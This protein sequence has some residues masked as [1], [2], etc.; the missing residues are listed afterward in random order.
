MFKQILSQLKN[1]PGLDI[2][3]NE[4]MSRH[5]TFKIGGPAR[6]FL[7]AHTTD[8][9]ASAYNILQK[10][11]ITPLILGNGSNLLVSDSG[12]DGI[13]LKL[14]CNKITVSGNMIF[15]E[16][17]ALLSSIASVAQKEALTGLEFAHG[18]PG[19]V[20]GAVVMNAGAYGGEI[21]D[22]L[23][24][25]VCLSPVGISEIPN[26]D[27]NFGYRDSIYKRNPSF[28]VLSASCFQ[29]KSVGWKERQP[30]MVE[31]QRFSGSHKLEKCQN[32]HCKSG[33]GC[34]LYR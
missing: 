23:T 4:L 27:H 6:F 12:Y 7:D 33:C 24:N 16:A 1:I 15:A 11:E 32:L 26:Q 29:I 5:T 34:A 20:G 28:T 8:A 25:S 2:L 3:E 9:A 31:V 30:T 18:I 10:N 13:I 19:T 14:S 22:V 17:G 21:S